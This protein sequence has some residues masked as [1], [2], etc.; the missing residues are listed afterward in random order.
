MQRVLSNYNR[1]VQIIFYNVDK[2]SI[3]EQMLFN[4]LYYFNSIY[5][6]VNAFIK[7]SNFKTY[8]LTGDRV[9]DNRENYERVKIVEHQKR[10][11]KQVF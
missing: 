2:L 4:E 7:E 3:E 10:L 9:L 6:D 8:F 1:M 11:V 5:F